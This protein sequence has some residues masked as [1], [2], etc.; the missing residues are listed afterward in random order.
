M[1]RPNSVAFVVVVLSLSV[2]WQCGRAPDGQQAATPAG[3]AVRHDVDLAGLDRSVN[4]GDDFFRFANGAWRKSTEIPPDRSNAS[5][6]S[7]L[8][9]QALQRTREL[10]EHAVAGAASAGPDERK[11]GDYYA[12]YMDEGAIEAKGTE[13]LKESLKT[14][15]AI[16]DRRALAEWIGR[17]LRAGVWIRRHDGAERGHLSGHDAGALR[18]SIA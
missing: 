2:T 16:S 13:P 9:E 10:L 18:G 12:S 4:P 7:V 1:N 11:V 5:T 6:F 15:A 17:S 14:I 3:P 8:G